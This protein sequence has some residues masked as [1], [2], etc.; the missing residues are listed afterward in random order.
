MDIRDCKGNDE[1]RT[2]FPETYAKLVKIH[3]NGLTEE[4]FDELKQKLDEKRNNG[5][6]D[7]EAN[8]E[9]CPD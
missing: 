2:R 7:R 8:T 6:P 9:Q 4:H 5:I 1:K 3:G